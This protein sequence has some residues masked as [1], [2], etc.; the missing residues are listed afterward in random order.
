MLRCLL[1]VV[2]TLRSG[3][4]TRFAAELIHSRVLRAHLR[5]VHAAQF[6]ARL[7]PYMLRC[8][9]AVVNTL[10]SGLLRASPLSLSTAASSAPL[11]AGFMR[12]NSPRSLPHTCCVVCW[13]LCAHCAGGCCAFRCTAYPQPPSLRAALCAT[14]R[15]TN[16]SKSLRT[17]FDTRLIHTRSVASLRLHANHIG[18]KLPGMSAPRADAFRPHSPAPASPITLTSPPARSPLLPRPRA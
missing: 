1:A 3:L 13:Q 14:V 16:H 9:L 4:R 18:S 2:N 10:R 6:T 17:R 15:F 11:C 8:L 12:R 7:A 5:G